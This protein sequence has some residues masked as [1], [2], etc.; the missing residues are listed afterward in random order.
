MLERQLAKQ[1]VES[2]PGGRR[3]GRRFFVPGW[4]AAVLVP[5]CALAQERTASTDFPSLHTLTIAQ[6]TQLEPTDSRS[7]ARI[8]LVIMRRVLGSSPAEAL[9]L[10]DELLTRLDAETAPDEWYYLQSLRAEALVRNGLFAD[11]EALLAELRPLS[12]RVSDASAR[13]AAMLTEGLLLVRTGKQDEAIPVYRRAR[14]VAEG[15]GEALLALYA[16]HNEAVSQIQLGMTHLA[17][18]QLKAVHEN[19]DLL[20]AD[21]SNMHGMTFNLAY[22]QNLSGEHESALSGF[23]HSRSV[24]EAMGHNV[25]SFIVTTQIARALHMLGRSDEAITEMK[26]WIER[27]DVTPGPDLMADALLVLGQACLATGDMSG[28]AGAIARAR[29]LVSESGGRARLAEFAVLEARL[30]TERNE[31]EAALDVIERLIASPDLPTSSLVYSEALLVKANILSNQGDFEQALLAQQRAMT[32][33]RELR[34]AE[35]DRQLSASLTANELAQRQRE[36]DSLRTRDRLTE[37]R[38]ERD[39]VYK[40]ALIGVG[41]LLALIAYLVW[42]QWHLERRARTRL[43]R[44]VAE[45]TSQVRD[46]ME[47]RV[48]AERARRGLENRLVEDEKFRAIARLTGGLAHDFNNLMTVVS[49]SAELVKLTAGDH[50]LEQLADDIL[51]AADAGTRV[52]RSLIAYTRQQAL[53]PENMRLDEFL[54]QNRELFQNTLGEQI[55]LT[56]EVTPAV[57]ELDRSSLTTAL[58]NVLFNAREAMPDHGRVTIRLS[59]YEA[60]AATRRYVRLTIEDNGR[61]MD[62][63]TRQRAMEPFFSTKSVGKTSGM[64]LGL[65][66]VYGFVRQSNGNVEIQSAPNKGTAI[67]LIFPAAEDVDTGMSDSGSKPLSR[68]AAVEPVVLLVEDQDKIRQLTRQA[69]EASGYRVYDC[70]NGADAIEALNSKRHFDVLVSDI[71]MP[72]PFNGLDVARVAGKIS[73]ETRV[74][75]TSGHAEVIPKEFEFLPKPYD[76]ATLLRRVTQLLGEIDDV[77]EGA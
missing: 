67:H 49:C 16:R 2:A 37:A 56:L 50:K 20:P 24:F 52:T 22:L 65:S 59:E 32:A 51:E 12:S 6:L 58:L 28:T 54:A 42:S 29:Q 14:Y 10:G 77:R 33:E 7:K 35:F 21:D 34:T 69:L 72:G 40:A 55:E 11:A 62:D 74:L 61:G 25:R 48:E 39:R 19:I 71:V 70:A 45:R 8:E 64:G 4:L 63:E 75:L 43:E 46:E 53:H 30:L 73:A 47:K 17:M 44:T 13:V 31:D 26:A 68:F 1:P 3:A 76:V 18:E 27:P 23:M 5:V 57:V 38:F 15:A 60:S 66:T 41:G 9:Q 36:L